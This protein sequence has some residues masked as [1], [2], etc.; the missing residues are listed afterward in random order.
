MTQGSVGLR[1]SRMVALK[2]GHGTP[3]F[4]FPGAPGTP[5]TFRDLA[6]QL[7]EDRPVYGFH[8]IGAQQECEPVRQI[9]RAAQL[10]AAELRSVQRHGPYF[11]FGYSFGGLV[12][13]ELARELVAQGE[14]IGLVIMAD[15]PA[16]G[17][18]PPAPLLTRVKTHANN[19]WSASR[20]AR[21][22]YLRQRA[23]NLRT[24][25]AKLVGLIPHTDPNEQMPD[26]ERR[27]VAAAYE[28]FNHYDPMPLGVDVLFLTA[29]T[30]P[31]W[32]TASF[33]DPLLGWGNMLR[34]RI[35]QCSIPGAHLSVFAP[36]N[37]PVLATRIR[38]GLARAER[39]NSCPPQLLPTPMPMPMPLPTDNAV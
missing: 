16:P 20:E 17:Y 7:G 25:V 12:A 13:F 14:R 38:E 37:L 31:E 9:S 4:V 21:V 1:A 35:S 6:A 19:L 15:S 34:G 10:Y 22:R 2:S 5:D 39:V 29:D 28:A 32:P 30:P 23:Q 3:L 24:R 27:L 26:H 8:H 33:D 11:L 36:R 18:P